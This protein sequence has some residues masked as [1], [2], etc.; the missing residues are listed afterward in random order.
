[1]QAASPTTAMTAAAAFTILALFIN[2]P[3]WV[4]DFRRS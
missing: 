4:V 2:V 3:F 1:V